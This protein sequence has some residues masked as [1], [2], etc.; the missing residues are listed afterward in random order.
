MET[1]KTLMKGLSLPIFA[2]GQT[3]IGAKVG[4]ILPQERV[5]K[6]HAHPSLGRKQETCLATF[7][8]TS[9]GTTVTLDRAK[10]WCYGLR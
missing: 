6:T 7:C 5:D 8:S 10:D 1:T 3:K 4:D 9:L 2:H